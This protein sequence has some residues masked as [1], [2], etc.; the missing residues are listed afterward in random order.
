MRHARTDYNARIQEVGPVVMALVAHLTT[1]D[2]SITVGADHEAPVLLEE[3]ARWM[4]DQGLEFNLEPHIG[5]DEPVFLLR[6]K[7]MLASDTV[8]TWAEWL[9]EDGGDQVTVGAAV[10]VAEAMEAW[11]RR[12]GFQAHLPDTP[13]ELL[14]EGFGGRTPTAGGGG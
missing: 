7:D 6:A 9:E 1:M 4:E 8:R 12:Q 14:A 3:V 11:Q 10:A 2:R 5:E 13:A